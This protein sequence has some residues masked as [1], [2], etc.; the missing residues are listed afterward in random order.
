MTDPKS[1]GDRAEQAIGVQAL[2]DRLRQEG[3]EA[4]RREGETLRHQAKD[5]AAEVIER[6][7]ADAKRIVEA[8][9]EKAAKLKSAGEEALRTATRDTVL[10]FS[11]EI[12]EHLRNRVERLVSE[13]MVDRDLLKQLVAQVVHRSLD[14]PTVRDATTLRVQ[15][16]AEPLGVDELKNDP[17]ALQ[18]ELSQLAKQI[19]GSTWREGVTFQAAETGEGVKVVVEEE[20]LEVDLTARAVTEL[21]MRHLQPRFRA[22]MRGIIQ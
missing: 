21:L 13:D 1:S 22:L 8:A 3:V 14:V 19:A 17:E 2:L 5:E 4:G 15:L 10:R 12:M 20:G 9:E 11:E 6:A 7:H 16:P 18:D